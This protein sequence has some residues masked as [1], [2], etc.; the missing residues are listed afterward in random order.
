MPKPNPSESQAPLAEGGHAPQTPPAPPKASGLPP[1][2]PPPAAL[3]CIGLADSTLAEALAQACRSGDG[4]QVQ[5][6]LV[7][8]E[9]D[10]N[11]PWR[12]QQEL[13]RNLQ[14]A[15]SEG[16]ADITAC[17][18]DHGANVQLA[19][20][21]ASRQRDPSIAISVFD[22]LFDHGLDLKPFPALLQYAV[23]LSAGGFDA[24][25]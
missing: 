14:Y 5:A 18:L 12:A 17:L 24:T 25:N 11:H 7:G 19:P 1:P 20:M 4:D 2:P 6:L 16:Y 22:V 9:K 13:D 23:N 3:P 8:L 21:N 10:P 15:A